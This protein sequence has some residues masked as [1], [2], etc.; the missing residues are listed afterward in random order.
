MAVERVNNLPEAIVLAAQ[1]ARAVLAAA[2]E[3]QVEIGPEVARDLETSAVQIGP[4]AELAAE[5]SQAIGQPA[6]AGPIDLVAVRVLRLALPAARTASEIGAR[7][8][9]DLVATARLV[10]AEGV[11]REPLVPVADTA[12]AVADLAAVEAEVVAEVVAAAEEVAVVA[13]EAAVAGVN[14]SCMRKTK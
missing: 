1:R 7:R 8:Q 14:T 12:W 6:E 9:A 4:V 10:A 3:L 2:R 5:V 13:V 11:P